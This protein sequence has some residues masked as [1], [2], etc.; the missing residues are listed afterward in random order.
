MSQGELH[1]LALA[2]FL[3]RAT[4]SASPFRF[5]VLDDPVQAMDPAKIDGLVKVLSNIAKER[6]VI[7]LSHDDR[8]PEAVR[9]SAVPARILE[10]SR[11]SNSVVAINNVRDPAVRYLSDADALIKDGRL[12]DATLRRAL[13]GILRLAAE[14]AARDRYF[15]TAFSGGAS[16]E[17]VEEAWE[18][19]RTTR[20]RVALAMLGSANSDLSPWMSRDARRRRAIEICGTA[21]HTG[22]R[23]DPRDAYEDVSRLVDDIKAGR[24]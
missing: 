5:V 14:S 24:R 4:M 8:L 6:Q 13:P 7:V 10:V 1:A 15:S 18:S 11:S 12:P 23:N 22:L 19:A 2:L 16:A 17:T 21:P 3:P 9:R 20:R